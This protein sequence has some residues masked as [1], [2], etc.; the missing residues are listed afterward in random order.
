MQLRSAMRIFLLL[1]QYVSTLEGLHQA[2]DYFGSAQLLCVGEFSPG[3][4]RGHLY[5]F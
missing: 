3:G 4:Q 1:Y 5:L 2:V